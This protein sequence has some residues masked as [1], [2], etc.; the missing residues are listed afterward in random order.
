MKRPPSSSDPSKFGFDPKEPVPRGEYEERHQ[1][2]RTEYEAFAKRTVRILLLIFAA[3]L[4]MMA[5]ATYLLHENK[6]R[7]Q[8]IRSTLI[9]N[10][11][12]NGNPLRSVVRHLGNVQIQRILADIKQ[13]NA[14]EQSGLYQKIFP[15]FPSDELKELLAKGR[16][17]DL[18]TVHGL[19][20]ATMHAMPVECQEKFAR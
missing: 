6:Q 15:N 4:L 10:C 11:E 2:L 3:T 7:T 13:R 5:I 17:R 9:E 20:K 14:F 19:R 1:L 16:K 12:R 18:N 8:D